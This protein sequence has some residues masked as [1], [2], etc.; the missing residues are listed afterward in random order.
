MQHNQLA[1]DPN[2]IIYAVR[3]SA[4]LS[5]LINRL[6]QEEL[7]LTHDEVN[8]LI[9]NTH[10]TKRQVEKKQAKTHRQAGEGDC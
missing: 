5:I 10:S 3:M 7:A 1:V 4:V 6:G 8:P 2:E 9:H